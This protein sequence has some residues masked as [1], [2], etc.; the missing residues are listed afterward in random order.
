MIQS[1]GAE[2]KM[3]PDHSFNRR[4]GRVLIAA[5][6]GLAGLAAGSSPGEEGRTGVLLPDG[7][8]FI[9]WERPLQF[10]RTFY[11]DNR[12]SGAADSNPGTMERPFL[13]INKAAQVLRPG[14]RVVIMT[15]VYRERIDPARGGNGPDTM[16]S[17]EA[18]PGAKVVVKG[19]RVVKTGWEPS[20]GFKL[21]RPAAAGPQVKIYQR[22]LDDL[23]FRGY[24]PF[25]MV[26]IMQDRVYLK[27]KPEELW[28][29]LARRGMIFVDGQRLRQVE[30]YQD[31][32]GK[33][34]CFWCE[35]DGL[36]IHMRLPGDADPAQHEVELVIQEQVFAP[37]TRGLGYL[38]VKGMTFEHAANAFPVPQRGMVSLNR[39]HHWIV[40]DCIL[41]HANAVALD[42]GAQDW[43]MEPPAVVGCAVVRRNQI[44]DVGVCGIAGMAVRDT[45][46]ESNLIEHV[47]YQ[48]VE[49]SWET[50]GI[51]LHATKNC[52]LRRNVIRHTIH[53]EA[54]WLDYENSNTRVTG[55]VMGDNLE[56]LRGGIYLE[57]SHDAN[58]IDNNII[59][60]A[61]EGAGGGSYN[62]PGHG[63]WGIT[64]DGSD[65]TVLAH[66]LI[67][68]T[69]DAAIKFRNIES[70][71]VS[72]RGGTARRNKVLNNIFYRCG[73]AIDFSNG[74]N[75]A[76]GNLYTKDWG[77]ARDET[78]SVGRGLNWIPDAGTTLRLDLEAWRK[79]FGF[80][81]HGAY[82]EMKID[83]DLDRLTMT[84]S[85]SGVIPQAS[86]EKHFQMD[87]LG[88]IADKIRKPGPLLRLPDSPIE[89]KIDPRR[90]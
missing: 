54:I 2:A 7:R 82:A 45:L 66:N 75:T 64:V 42:I 67:G 80:D 58:M 17:Y 59:W 48:D 84:W 23:E 47:G 8:E 24:N 18:A 81:Q 87:L 46:I 9:S 52:L 38:R 20:L 74:D 30:L 83:V 15:G 6:L 16:I 12:N 62:M 72:G 40:E 26:N 57:A 49:L 65:E 90:R 55:N 33:D 37:R 68:L 27:P 35:H 43:D 36:A 10:A 79:F 34:G 44:D 4:F 25:G 21:E 19:S 14:E 88:Q 71:I 41:R 5:F 69:Q 70:R 22:R 77:G 29:H 56:T 39:G 89:V 3:E 78:E 85:V 63:G 1:D 61:T 60:K 28:R 13:T 86:T 76:D 50:G 53:A 11:V 31:L 73:K 32:G 51:K